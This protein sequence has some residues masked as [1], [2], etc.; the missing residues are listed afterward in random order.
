MTTQITQYSSSQPIEPAKLMQQCEMLDFSVKLGNFFSQSTLVPDNYRNKPNDC[1]VAIL[2]GAELGIAPL[3]A[4]QNI[5]VI[6]GRPTLWGDILVA[7]V[8][9]SG[10]C[11]Y[12]SSEY[13]AETRTATVSTRRK[14]EKDESRSF[15]WNDATAAG[16][17][18][19]DTYKRYPQRML[20]ARARSYLLRDVYADVLKGFGVREIEEEDYKYISATVEQT[21]SE[22]LNELLE[23][24]EHNDIESRLDNASTHEELEEIRI[25]IR[26]LPAGDQQNQ[27]KQKW[28]DT[29]NR[30]QESLCEESTKQSSSETSETLNAASDR[31]ENNLP[32]SQSQPTN[33]GQTQPE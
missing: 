11:E 16:I 31:A 22:T 9:A 2:W 1:A 6:N 27:L 18:H 12:L 10:L 29:R 26:E 5:A 21:K 3:Q 32:D 19:K 4:L 13:N 25:S 8:K 20:S 33:N 24:I 17:S 15:S 30:L 14:G 7:L 23:P 28:V